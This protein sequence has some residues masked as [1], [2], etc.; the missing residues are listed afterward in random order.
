[1]SFYVAGHT[2]SDTPGGIR[3]LCGA[4]WHNVRQAMQDDVNK[5]NIAHTGLLTQGEL[6]MILSARAKEEKAVWD[7]ITDAASA[8]S[9]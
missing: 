5:P 1:M 4:F 8:G 7:A 9:R 6:D 3:C 2:F